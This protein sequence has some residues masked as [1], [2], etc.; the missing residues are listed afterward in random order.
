MMGLRI[1]QRVDAYE[2]E[3]E[4]RMEEK[5]Q[6]GGD[7]EDGG[8]R[9]VPEDSDDDEGGA[10]FVPDDGG[11]DEGMQSEEYF[12]DGAGGFFPE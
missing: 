1:K 12:S 6:A 9:F 8:G 11:D 4:E 7:E 10:G 3:G 5:R 2:I